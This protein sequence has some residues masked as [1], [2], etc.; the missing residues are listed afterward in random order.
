M[1]HSNH[2][3]SVEGSSPQCYPES[4]SEPTPGALSYE[5]SAATIPGADDVSD[6]ELMSF[7]TG[8]KAH[9]ATGPGEALLPH[10]DDDANQ[11]M[12]DIYPF[13]MALPHDSS[14]QALE[15]I[16]TN[17]EEGSGSY[18]KYDEVSPGF[19]VPTNIGYEASPSSFSSRS[20]TAGH[21]RN[22]F[23][24]SVPAQELS[25]P[26]S[27]GCGFASNQGFPF[28]TDFDQ[29][30]IDWNL[31]S[32]YA[33]QIHQ[34]RSPLQCMP[35]SLNHPHDQLLGP[36]GEVGTP[37]ESPVDLK[38]STALAFAHSA[39]QLDPENPWSTA[40]RQRIDSP[41]SHI[42]VHT[43]RFVQP[44]SLMSHQEPS[45]KPTDPVPDPRLAASG[46]AS[47]LPGNWETRSTFGEENIND[48]HKP[49][50]RGVVGTRSSRRKNHAIEPLTGALTEAKRSRDFAHSAKTSDGKFVCRRICK[51]TEEICGR[52]FQRSE[53]LKRHFATHEELKPFQCAICERYFGRTDNL[54]QHIKTH[55]NVH[56]RNTKLLRA[57]L[58][59][60]TEQNKTG[61]KTGRKP[62]GYNGRTRA[63]RL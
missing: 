36:R 16:T 51:D 19:L 25:S 2:Q 7:C 50:K 48:N 55:E 57:K 56:G 41:F 3:P 11:V 49:I 4:W 26:L 53:H 28:Y 54:T 39:I 15:S 43:S 6:L 31:S 24:F 29:S 38:S 60:K 5:S 12:P 23:R 20:G 21:E 30:G 10:F 62:T 45:G 13:P 59:Q 18:Q 58:L 47:F 46:K 52:K 33:T 42:E 32:A 1:L 34:N 61:Q 17:F 63:S 8:F 9:C 22:D 35:I 14:Y 40:P 44:T 37:I 27:H